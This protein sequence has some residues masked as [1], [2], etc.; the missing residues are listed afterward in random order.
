MNIL[1]KTIG[2]HGALLLV[3]LGA[4]RFQ[5]KGVVNILGKTIGQH[6]ALLLILLG[7][8]RFQHLQTI[9]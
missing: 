9:I 8:I 1:G 5:H 6:A 3:L 7:D 2:Q 4:I